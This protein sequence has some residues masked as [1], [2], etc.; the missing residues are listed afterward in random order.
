MNYIN[1]EPLLGHSTSENVRSICKPLLQIDI[2]FF[3]YCEIKNDGSRISLTTHP[4][5]GEIFYKNC[6]FYSASFHQHPSLY[7]NSFVIWNYARE[8]DKFI[9]CRR[10]FGFKNG[11]TLIRK[12]KN[13]CEFYH[14]SS[15]KIEEFQNNFFIEIYDLLDRF[16]YYFKEKA[17][18]LINESNNNRLYIP[19]IENKNQPFINNAKRNNFINNIKCKKYYLAPDFYFSRREIDLINYI[20]LGKSAEETALILNISTKTVQRHIANIKNKINCSKNTEI[21]NK[22]AELSGKIIKFPL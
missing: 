8:S 16:T 17:S 21:L 11:I 7:E 9:E 5:W 12:H 14:F 18:V 6:L 2:D 19:F 13:N 15:S 20:A 4:L 10:S 1:L 22:I 3:H